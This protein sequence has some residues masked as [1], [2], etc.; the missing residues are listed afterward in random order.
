V[1]SPS[2]S[3]HSR[4]RKTQPPRP[5]HRPPTRRRRRSRGRSV[6]P[7]LR[8]RK[9][10]RL[11]TRASPG[12]AS[13]SRRGNSPASSRPFVQGRARGRSLRTRTPVRRRRPRVAR[14]HPRSPPLPLANHRPLLLPLPRRPHGVR[15]SRRR[16]RRTPRRLGQA[17]S[18]R[19]SGGC[20]VRARGPGLPEVPGLGAG[21]PIHHRHHRP[22]P[23]SPVGSAPVGSRTATGQTTSP[24]RTIPPEE[25]GDRVETTTWTACGPEADPRLRRLRPPAEGSRARRPDDQGVDLADRAAPADPDRA[26][27]RPRRVEAGR[28]APPDPASSPGWSRPCPVRSGPPRRGRRRHPGPPRPRRPAGPPPGS[29][30]ARGRPPSSWWW[31]WP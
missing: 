27:S 18:P 21:P 23:Q 16:P 3:R 31:G 9:P 17:P 29:G 11:P 8:R 1:S 30:A 13:R 5:R 2:S 6:R 19:S 12:R 22:G 4:R 24:A 15:T 28:R 14:H 7:S 20:R 26:R 10:R 25:G